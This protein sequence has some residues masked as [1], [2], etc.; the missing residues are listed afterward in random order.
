MRSTSGNPVRPPRIPPLTPGNTPATPSR[1]PR[2]MSAPPPQ[3][4]ERDRPHPL[5]ER[6]PQSPGESSAGPVCPGSTHLHAPTRTICNE[7]G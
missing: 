7:L 1:A 5:G 4:E 2:T 3:R 6:R